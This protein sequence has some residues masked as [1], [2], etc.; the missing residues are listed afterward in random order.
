MLFAWPGAY[1]GKLAEDQGQ[2]AAIAMNLREMF[3][4]RVPVF[5]VV[6]GEGGSAGALAIGCGNVNMMLENSVYYVAS[7]EAVAQS[8][9]KSRS[10][11]KVAAVRRSPTSG[12]AEICKLGFHNVLRR[13][14]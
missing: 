14:F 8:F 2:G 9:S 5:T 7:P 1:A 4:L 10:K 3:G 11:E 6:I 13:A 12:L